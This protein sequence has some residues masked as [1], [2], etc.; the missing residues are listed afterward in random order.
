MGDVPVPLKLPGEEVAV[1][2]TDPVPA[3]VG[4]VNVTVAVAEPVAVAV[5]IVGTAGLLGHVPANI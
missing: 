2:V 4:G 5:P 1:Y 3:S